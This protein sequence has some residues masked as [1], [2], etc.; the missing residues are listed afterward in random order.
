MDAAIARMSKQQ[1]LESSYRRKKLAPGG[2]IVASLNA[3]ASG[4]SPQQ[5]LLSDQMS[6]WRMQRRCW[7][8]SGCGGSSASRLRSPF[9]RSG[10]AAEPVPAPPTASP[11]SPSTRNSLLP[12]QPQLLGLLV[13][14]W[15]PAPH[16]QPAAGS[17]SA[18]MPVRRLAA[19]A[20]VHRD[21]AA[22]AAKAGGNLRGGGSGS[23]SGRG[24][25][26]G[27]ITPLSF[28]KTIDLR[29]P[30]VAGASGRS[31][32]TNF[33][34]VSLPAFDEA[35]S[36]AA[37]SPTSP[38][39]SPTGPTGICSRIMH[40]PL[41]TETQRQPGMLCRAAAQKQRLTGQMFSCIM[42]S[43]RVQTPA[44]VRARTPHARDIRSVPTRTR[45][46][47]QLSPSQPS[48]L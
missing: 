6:S 14:D 16:N 46:L 48:P 9:E 42:W 3:H 23:A 39:W 33:R 28:G 10:T 29:Q 11:S 5:S 8:A 31:N 47:A 22:A 21:P 34:A 36:S 45:T 32:A 43:R 19:L 25:G 30:P 7:T 41:L 38:A 4:A 37:S 24:A 40:E 26:V 17:A 18:P 15:T 1:N 2:G 12:S 13:Q 27:T 35:A 20:A 44:S